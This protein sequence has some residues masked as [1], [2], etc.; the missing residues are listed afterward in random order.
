MSNLYQNTLQ[1]VVN[2]ASTH[3]D[4]LPLSGVGGYTDEPAL[5]LCNDALS[6]LLF[7]E[8]DWKFNRVEAPMMVTAQN[9]QDY[10]IAGAVAFT[11]GST[12]TG[13]HIGLATTP[14]I[15]ESGTTVTVNTLEPHRFNIADTVY[16]SGNTVAAY[17]SAF[18]DNG[19]SAAWSGGWVITAVPTST[20][21]TFTHG[22]S[23]LANSGAPGI[24]DFG[25]LASAS[26]TQ[27][28]D[29]SSPQDGRILQAVKELSVWKRVANPEKVCV[30]KDNGDGTLKVRF[31]YTPGSTIWA[32]NLV[33]QA[34][35]P[36]KTSLADDW[37][38]FPDHY[39]AVYRQALLYRMYRYLN[40]GQQT[41]EFQ[42][43]Q[44]EIAKANGAE[45]RET[46]N[47]GLVP[48]DGSFLDG[49]NYYNG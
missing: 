21:F 38:P 43:L 2:L 31:W 15:T 45:D 4:L 41:V 40:N 7:S 49:G 13:A 39:S 36:L 5:S 16:M 33:Y 3:A 42:K 22:S 17:N 12:S 18:T 24:S 9:K 48:E 25:W 8:I 6:D 35:A 44:A 28:N 32:V 23:G 14:A 34:K 46:T 10:L 20:S 47:I 26:M 37:S 1:G 30:L 19:S 11:L 27:L 29:T